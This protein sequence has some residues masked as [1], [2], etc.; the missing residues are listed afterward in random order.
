MSNQNSA[1]I[2]AIHIMC[3][4][5]VANYC[6]GQALIVATNA[7]WNYRVLQQSC[8]WAHGMHIFTRHM[9]QTHTHLHMHMT[10]TDW[11]EAEFYFQHSFR[12]GLTFTLASV[13]GLSV[14]S[15]QQSCRLQSKR[16]CKLHT[17]IQ[18]L[19]HTFNVLS[20]ANK[21]ARPKNCNNKA[22]ILRWPLTWL[23]LGHLASFGCQFNEWQEGH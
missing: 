12:L 19:V 22:N 11:T 8:G 5:T 10:L 1:N 18:L 14:A 4:K 13:C 17:H 16:K 2:S 23:A 9:E 7:A 6:L 3:A 15:L 20:L 21:Y